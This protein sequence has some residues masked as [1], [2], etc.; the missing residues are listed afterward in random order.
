[1][2][3]EF[4]EVKVPRLRDNGP[5]WWQGCQPYAPAVFTS[6]RY[7]WYLFLL[8]AEST[9]CHGAIG[10]IMSMKGSNDIIGNRTSDLPICSAAP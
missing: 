10:G 7:S 5:E 3:R 2:P 1:M 9:Q 4:Q 6:R 8:E